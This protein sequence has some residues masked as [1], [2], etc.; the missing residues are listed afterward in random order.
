LKLP[1][2]KPKSE[3]SNNFEVWDEN[4]DIV[5]MFLRMQ[6]QWEVSMSGY[7]GL[8]YD[9]LL[10]SGGLFDLYDV[11]N[12]REVLEGLQVMES[13]ALSEFRKKSDG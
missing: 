12:R 5:M 1:A 7:V 6:T 8:K 2:P 3:E 4:W 13:T 10:V 11:E 9:V